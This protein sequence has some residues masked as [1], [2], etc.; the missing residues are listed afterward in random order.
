[1]YAEARGEKE[2]EKEEEEEVEEEKEESSQKESPEKA[3]AM[4]WQRFLHALFADSQAV[5]RR[6]VTRGCFALL[7]T[8][9]VACRSSSLSSRFRR[10]SYD[11]RLD[12]AFEWSYCS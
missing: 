6:W 5:M 8:R 3:A 2:E 10:T 1:M 9:R 11:G 12:S 4:Y 7:P